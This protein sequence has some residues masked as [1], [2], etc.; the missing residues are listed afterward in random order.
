MTDSRL[1]RRGIVQRPAIMPLVIVPRTPSRASSKP[2]AAPRQSSGETAAAGCSD[3]GPL[4]NEAAS[5]EGQ[6]SVGRL[7]MAAHDAAA[8]GDALVEHACITS[9]LIADAPAG[10]RRSSASCVRAHSGST[11]RVRPGTPAEAFAIALG[12]QSAAPRHDLRQAL[13]LLAAD[14]RLDVRHAVVVAQLRDTTRRSPGSRRGA[15]CR[16]RSCACWRSR[17][18]SSSQSDWRS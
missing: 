6:V 16:A 17:R 4:R 9:A 15:P 13:E 14:R 1:V 11:G 3:P 12:E 7:A 2:A 18:N 10:A 8:C 5:T